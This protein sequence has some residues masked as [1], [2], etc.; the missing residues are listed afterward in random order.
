MMSVLTRPSLSIAALLVVFVVS[1]CQLLGFQTAAPRQQAADPQLQEP[2]ESPMIPVSGGDQFPD[3]LEVVLRPQAD[4][5]YDVAVTLSSPYDTP[6]RY[7]DGWRVMDP[8]GNTLGTRM[9]AH[10]HANEQPFTRTQ[11]GLTIP[12]GIDEVTV[13]GRDQANG[14]G[15][16]TVTVPVPRE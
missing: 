5:T 2:E 11:R 9:L 14:F 4:G 15:G 1:G 13:E 8:D 12:E 10:D 3:V 16:L 6:Q 7:A